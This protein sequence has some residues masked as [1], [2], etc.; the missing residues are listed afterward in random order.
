[1]FRSAL[2]AILI[3]STSFT[4]SH[5]NS[6]KN[7]MIDGVKFLDDIPEV[8][9]YRVDGRSLIIGWKGIPKIFPRTNRR[10]RCVQPYLPEGKSM[11]GQSAT[12]RKNGGSEAVNRISA[13]LQQKMAE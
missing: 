5:A 13:L 8:E 11:S 2:F 9:W 12:T 7:A 6:L 10:A 1:M 4:F 3:L